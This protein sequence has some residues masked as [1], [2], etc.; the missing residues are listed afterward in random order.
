MFFKIKAKYNFDNVLENCFKSVSEV[1]EKS[2]FQYIDKNIMKIEI[3][4]NEKFEFKDFYYVKNQ[5]PLFSQYL[6]D[7]IKIFD[8]VDNLFLKEVSLCYDGEKERYFIAV[9]SRIRC[10]DYE[11]SVFEKSGNLYRVKKA[12]ISSE[13]VGRYIIFKAYGVE[14][15]NIYVSKRLANVLK[16]DDVI[17]ENI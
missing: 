6:M 4:E 5:V 3:S 11:N 17:V 7:K 2:E 15:D 10:F 12:V 8:D 9:P 14:D 13:N 1:C 16:C